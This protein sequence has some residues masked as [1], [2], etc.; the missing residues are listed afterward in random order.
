V[1]T[2]IARALRE[3]NGF[4]QHDL[5]A[6]ARDHHAAR[7]SPTALLLREQVSGAAEPAR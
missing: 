5:A 4:R 3:P 2:V 7:R 1:S 6:L